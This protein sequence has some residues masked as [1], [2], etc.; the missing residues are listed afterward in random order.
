VLS[1]GALAIVVFGVL[2]QFADFGKATDA[3]L[4]L[5]A[6]WLTALLGATVLSVVVYATQWQAA[7]RELRYPAAFSIANTSFMISNGIPGGGAIVLP[8]Q[9]AMLADEG[10]DRHRSTAATAVTALWNILATLLVPLIGV[11]FL[12]GTG[13]STPTWWLTI[14]AGV[15]GFGIVALLLRAL[16]R[17]SAVARSVGEFAERLANA[18]LR[19]VRRERSLGW[20]DML[21]RFR[22]STHE[23][24]STR[25]LQ[26]SVAHMAV[27]LTQF[28]VLDIALEGL[29]RDSAQSTTFATTLFAFGVARLGTFIPISPGGL[30]TVDG[31]LTAL[32][33]SAGNATAATALAAVLIWRTLTFLPGMVL[34]SIS[35]LL[36]RKRSASLLAARMN[37][38]DQS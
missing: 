2:P 25:W 24:L 29:Q 27:Q 16:V 15:T 37:A 30:G 20:G 8:T 22:E 33:V 31:A 19:F 6:L 3:A 5:P 9:Y 14:A 38:G 17:S 12:V 21:V 35:F 7:V 4:G 23:L 1:A 18:V 26:I 36:W 10:I 28:A 11:C 34:G 32:L 13:D